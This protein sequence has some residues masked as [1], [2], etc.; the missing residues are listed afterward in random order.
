L[1]LELLFMVK[2]VLGVDEAGRGAVVGP[3]CIG[4][5][6]IEEGREDELK[7][8]GV[9]DSK[10]LTRKKRESLEEKIKGIA[11]DFAVV[12]ISAKKIDEEMVNRSLNMIESERM[13]G[14][15]DALRPDKVI[16]DAMEARTEKVERVIRGLLCDD[17]KDV[18][19]VSENR[20]DENHV[21]VSA[22]SVLAKVTRDR[23]V[24]S[25]EKRTGWVIGNGYPSDE[26][27]KKFLRRV[28]DQEGTFPETV[29]RSWVTS[30]RI[31]E[32]RNQGDLSDFC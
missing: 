27:T 29:R 17:L 31:I 9:K 10:K 18:E 25:I 5:V 22:A 30:Q 3:L 11:E 7:R 16:I 8:M 20:A 15:I 23:S 28:I 2:L 14:L 4:A 12:K 26:R 19:I 1:E 6:V 24:S 21:V 13:A 32:E